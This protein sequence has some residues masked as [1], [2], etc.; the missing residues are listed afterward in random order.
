MSESILRVQNLRV[1]F[2]HRHGELVPIDDVSFDVKKGEILGFVGESG[3]GKSMTGAAIIGLIDPPGYVEKGE[4]WLENE[5]IDELDQ[6]RSGT[7]RHANG[8]PLPW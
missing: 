3:A 6:S 7:F 1:V 5:R 4:I 2:P 8:E